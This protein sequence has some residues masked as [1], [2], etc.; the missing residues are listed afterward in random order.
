[1]PSTSVIPNGNIWN[2]YK[3]FWFIIS[4][5]KHKEAKRNVMNNYSKVAKYKINIKNQSFLYTWQYT[6]YNEIEKLFHL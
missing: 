5:F 6:N 3:P 1:M 2:N 4:W